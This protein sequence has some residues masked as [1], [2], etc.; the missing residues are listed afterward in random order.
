MPNTKNIITAKYFRYNSK[1]AYDAANAALPAIARVGHIISPIA[2][3]AAKGTAPLSPPAIDLE[4]IAIQ[5]GPGVRKRIEIPKAQ[6]ISSLNEIDMSGP[7]R[8]AIYII[9]GEID[10]FNI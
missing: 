1:S 4:I 10:F 2:T 8:L 5:T 3:P 6:K 7:I 9:N